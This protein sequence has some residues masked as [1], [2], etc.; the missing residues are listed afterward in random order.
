MTQPV[1]VRSDGRT[2][3]QLRPVNM[4]LNFIKHAEGSVLIEA[5]DTR[6]VCTASVAGVG[7]SRIQ[8][9]GTP[10]RKCCCAAR[11]S[12]SSPDNHRAEKYRAGG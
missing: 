2:P 10:N 6:V 3:D 8:C 5:G 1:K 4:H 12:A 7:Q 11:A 9:R